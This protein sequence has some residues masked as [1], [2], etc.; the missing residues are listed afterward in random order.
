MNHGLPQ[1]AGYDSDQILPAYC[2]SCERQMMLGPHE[3]ICI[4]CDSENVS[5]HRHMTLM[6][7]LRASGP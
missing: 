2:F 3:R 5:R 6:Q 7:F 4:L 1:S